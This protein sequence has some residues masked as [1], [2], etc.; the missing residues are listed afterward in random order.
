MA[1]NISA[2]AISGLGGILGG[3]LSGHSAATKQIDALLL[4]AS[5]AANAGDWQGVNQIASQ[6]MGIKG[7]SQA[8]M[9]GARNLAH[10]ASTAIQTSVSMQGLPGAQVELTKLSQQQLILSEVNA[11]STQ[12]HSENSGIWH[13][14]W[15]A[16]RLATAGTV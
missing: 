10:A 12:L 4:E 6:I 13:H 2:N 5:N 14:L 1:I 16:H 9:S 7:A 15:G 11:L 3:L 8:M